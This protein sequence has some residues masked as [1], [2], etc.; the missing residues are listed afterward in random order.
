[1][2]DTEAAFPKHYTSRSLS[3]YQFLFLLNLNLLD[4]HVVVISSHSEKKKKNPL[5]IH[6][7]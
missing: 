6:V 4:K 5:E 2:H 3:V 7:C 1:M